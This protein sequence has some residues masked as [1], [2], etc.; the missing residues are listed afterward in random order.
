[1]DMIRAVNR[2]PAAGPADWFTGDVVIELINAAPAPA[3]VQ[4]A[5]VTFQPGARTAW[6]RHP[7]G[8]TLV[9]EAGTALIGRED[10]SVVRAEPGDAV[11]F[12][13]GER[14]WHGATA[15]AAMTHM[16]I[17]EAGEDGKATNWEEHV[18]DDAYATA[19][20]DA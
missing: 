14:H 5:R 2:E 20:A 12:A 4:I 10:G 18:G 15:D 19:P 8:Q 16:A 11:W 1:M 9:I 13:A 6:H 17:Q 7:L 3:R